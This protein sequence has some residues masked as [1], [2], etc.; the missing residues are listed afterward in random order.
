MKK[1]TLFVT[2]LLIV[3]LL[4]MAIPSSAAAGNEPVGDRIGLWSSTLEFTAGIPFNIRHGWLQTS[5]DGAIGIFDFSLEVDGA[6]RNEDFKLF[7]EEVG[8]PD[9]LTRLWVYNFPS[10]MSGTHTFTGHWYAP[11]QYAVSYL[12]Y[13]GTCSTPNEKVETNSRTLVVT[14]VPGS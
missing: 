5:D 12:G 13:Q 9:I 2:V 1:Q 4:S 10:G 14:F 3:T 6:L 8:E 7:S 11:C